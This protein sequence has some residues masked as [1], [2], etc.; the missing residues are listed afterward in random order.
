M[1]GWIERLSQQ[2]ARPRLWIER[3]VIFSEPDIEHRIRSIGF[4]PGLNLIWAHEPED[5]KAYA[6]IHAAGHGVGKTSLCLLLRY[7]LGDGLAASVAAL[8]ETLY[9]EFPQ[10]G[11]GAVVHVGPESFSVFRY[12]NAH[13]EGMA[14]NGDDLAALLQNGGDQSFKAF[15]TYLA[16]SLM[17]GVSPRAIPETGQAI[18]WPHV[19]AWI[20]RDQGTRFKSFYA[21]RDGEG[22]RLQRSR[23]DP[24]IVMR[25]VLGLLDRG[26]SAL[27]ARIR[28]LE[29]E[30][31]A[32]ELETARL[33]QE[34]ELIRRRIESELRAWLAVPP[35]LPLRTD[36]LFKD[37]VETKIL[38]AQAKATANLAELEKKNEAVEE[39]LVELRAEWLLLK[40]DYEEADAEFLSSNSA[41]QSDEG[42]F[43]ESRN[44]I[45]NLRGLAGQPCKHGEIDLGKCTHIQEEIR[46]LEG[47]IDMKAR[48]DQGVLAQAMDDWTSRAAQALERR[49]K[50]RPS[51]DK[52]QARV[53]EKERERKVLRSKRDLAT[54]DLARG[55]RLR[56]ELDRWT[57]AAGSKEAD[58]AI[59]QSIAHTQE[60]SRNLDRSRTDLA[61]RHRE[62][63]DREQ[64]LRILVNELTRALMSD[65][66][67]GKFS[68]R[69]ED[70]PFQLSVHGGEAYRVLEVLLGDLACLL[71]SAATGSAFPGLLIHDCPREADMSAGLYEA[72][73]LLAERVEREA[74][75]DSAPFQ[76]IVTT[77]TPPPESLRQLPCLRETLDPSTDDG[78]LFRRRF[79]LSTESEFLQGV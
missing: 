64:Q 21:W 46:K 73:L 25:A 33:K 16:E 22:T 52:A 20:S 77:T 61:V 11:V 6:G 26:E 23:Q 3:L 7:C 55:D 49:D 36:D 54:A 59:A 53:S 27:L 39:A 14:G 8:R 44:R 12:F 75:G 24:P 60:I 67:F 58:D 13:R 66:A 42:A 43:R 72:F 65:E 74:Y 51:L 76:Y 70:R 71:D 57:R 18:Q 10:G 38:E 30:F 50:L 40:R 5:R 28:G 69:D 32:S 62:Q 37:S 1:D 15:E 68:S 31:E 29:R 19:L 47:S 45:V 35:E 78:L 56:S 17:S 79:R 4:R 63:S 2:K 34:P 41:R 48:R 9:G